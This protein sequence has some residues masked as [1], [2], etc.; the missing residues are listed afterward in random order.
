RAVASRRTGDCR[1]SSTASAVTSPDESPGPS[2][3][4]GQNRPTGRRP[5]R[6]R[7][8]GAP[9]APSPTRGGSTGGSCEDGFRAITGSHGAL[10]TYR[11]NMGKLSSLALTALVAVVFGF[12]GAL[13]A[14]ALMAADLRGPQGATG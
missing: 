13:T 9:S 7:G 1:V 14:T 4:G 2:Y 5:P 11:S 6:Y 3:T 10:R 12:L 8:G